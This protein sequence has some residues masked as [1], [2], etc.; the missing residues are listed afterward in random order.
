MKLHVVW[1]FVTLQ[2]LH[3]FSDALAADSDNVEELVS[4]VFSFMII[5]Q[6]E[7]FSVD[8]IVSELMYG[9]IRLDM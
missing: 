1:K 8:L 6:F 3:Q 7:I 9:W 4:T 5:F 2:E